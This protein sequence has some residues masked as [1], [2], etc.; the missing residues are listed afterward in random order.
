MSAAASADSPKTGVVPL[1]YFSQAGEEKEAK[2]EAYFLD[3]SLSGM[4]SPACARARGIVKQSRMRVSDGDFSSLPFM[5]C[6]KSR[7]V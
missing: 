7:D 1:A 4:K 3:F 2:Q 5:A 6:D